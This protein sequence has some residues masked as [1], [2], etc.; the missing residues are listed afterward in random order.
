MDQP[1]TVSAHTRMIA[2]RWPLIIIPAIIAVIVA[3]GL[4]LMTPVRYTATATLLA[5]VQLLSWRWDNKLYDVIDTR[6]DWRGEVMSL[7]GSQKLAELVLASVDGQLLQPMDATA[8]RAATS[9]RPGS[10]ASLF[11]LSVSA[12]SPADAA[13]LANAMATTLPQLVAASYG[14]DIQSNQAAL[15]SV[16][17]EFDHYDQQL[18]DFRGRTGIGL[19][20][21]GDV[22]VN[23]E[24]QV[25]GAQS[26]IKTELT[27][28]N[29]TRAALTDLRDRIDF[30]LA[31][32][33]AGESP[34]SV[35]LLNVPELEGYGIEIADLLQ[36]AQANPR[37]L[38]ATLQALRQNVEGDLG[39]L[40]ENVVELQ[41]EHAR[42][43]QEWEDILQL[44]GVWLESLT[45]LERRDVELQ[46]KSMIEGDR[47]QVFSEATTPAKPSQPNWPLTLAIALAGGLLFGFLLA[48]AVVYLSD[49]EA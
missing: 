9:T 42:Q 40:T 21:G 2:R 15:E 49:A 31:A 34:V 30:V 43:S 27:L 36:Q 44:R 29:S 8:L 25:V 18:L 6:F 10:G 47:V 14:G 12:D 19:G 13:L 3:A 37:Q 26:A 23:D 35:G 22:A 5:P 1:I 16:R 39:P 46:L 11:T 33:A 28:K 38:T 7:A 24:Q 17:T 45:A 20:F 32:I 48:V 41:Y 4:A